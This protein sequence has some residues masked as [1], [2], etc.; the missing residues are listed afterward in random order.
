MASASCFGLAGKTVLREEF[1]IEAGREGGDGGTANGV[2]LD[3]LAR[4]IE[5]P[6]HGALQTEGQ[7]VNPGAGEEPEQLRAQ[8]VGTGL[9]PHLDREI[10]PG[11]AFE[12]GVD[13][14]GVVR[15]VRVGKPQSALAAAS[16]DGD[17]VK[18]PLHRMGAGGRPECRRG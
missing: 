6:G 5:H 16:D 12:D 17:V 14:I 7:G 13:P 18:D 9:D 10:A 15:E 8:H 2:G 3:G 1:D 4:S 11:D